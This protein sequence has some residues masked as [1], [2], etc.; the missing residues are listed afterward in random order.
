MRLNLM[1]LQ[2]IVEL[3]TMTPTLYIILLVVFFS[4]AFVSFI[5]MLASDL[6][7]MKFRIS[8]AALAIFLL[9]G[10]FTSTYTQ[11]ARNSAIR[12]AK[13]TRSDDKIHV[14]SISEFMKS[15]DLDVVAEKD[16]Y[17][18]VEFENKT[19]RIEDLS[20]KGN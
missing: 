8:I 4:L 11:S 7:D 19:Y 20:K 1:Q 9:S 6:D 2:E 13:I 10:L 18:Y 3:L 15:A 14:E 5:T 16:G 17:I 12:S